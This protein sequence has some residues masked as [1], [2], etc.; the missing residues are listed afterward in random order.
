[1]TR[2]GLGLVLAMLGCKSRAHVPAS[3]PAHSPALPCT[4][5]TLEADLEGCAH[6]RCLAGEKNPENPDCVCGTL[7]LLEQ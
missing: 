7:S 3:S 6:S 2:L 4:C 5:G 1:M